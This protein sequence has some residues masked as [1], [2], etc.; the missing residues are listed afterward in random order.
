MAKRVT[1][2][3]RAIVVINPNNPTGA[4]YNKETLAGIVQLANDNNLLL[5]SDEIYDNILFDGAKHYPL[6]PMMD[7]SSFCD[8]PMT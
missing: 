1:P 2:K 3:T 5:M 6:A 4:V 8:P 7:E